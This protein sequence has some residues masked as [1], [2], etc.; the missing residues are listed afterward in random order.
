[1]IVSGKSMKISSDNKLT[2]RTTT[3]TATKK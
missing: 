2:G 3:Y 1:M